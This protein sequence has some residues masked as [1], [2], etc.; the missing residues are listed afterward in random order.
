M[1]R[2]RIFLIAIVAVHLINA[3]VPVINDEFRTNLEEAQRQEKID[4]FELPYRTTTVDLRGLVDLTDYK[5]DESVVITP[6]ENLRDFNDVVVLV[7]LFGE[8][9]TPTMI[10]MLAGNYDS[11]RVTFFTDQNQD[12]DFTNDAVPSRVIKG[13]DSSN[14]ILYTEAGEQNLTLSLPE[15]TLK[16]ETKLKTRIEEGFSIALTGGVGSGN[17]RYSYDDLTIGFPTNYKVRVTEKMFRAALAYD[18]KRFQFGVSTS[19][20]N[21]FFYTS[22]LS[23]KK[24]ERER[25]TTPNGN[26]VVI[27]NVDEHINE[28]RHG[29]NKLQFAIFTAYKFYVG[30][31][32]DIQPI[33]A[34]G[35][36]SYLN[37]EYTHRVNQNEVYALGASPFYEVGI[38]SEFAIGIERS[39]FIEVVRNSTVWEPEN[40]LPDVERENFDSGILVTKINFGVRFAL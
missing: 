34:F 28:D 14:I 5:I 38:R 35:L 40:F 26:V 31:I 7:G 37:P 10:V 11:R 8:V 23:V 21:F 13:T 9:E 24:G 17:I 3:Q 4:F 25:I 29:P 22:K 1:A 18:V 2:A 32:A 20:Q 36:T 27:E 33:V 30:K 6:P 15:A 16:K 39:F 19:F 12:R